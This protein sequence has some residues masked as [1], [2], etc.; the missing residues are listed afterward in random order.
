MTS[1]YIR[2]VGSSSRIVKDV[3]I[4]APP[5]SRKDATTTIMIPFQWS[6]LVLIIAVAVAVVVVVVG[7]SHFVVEGCITTTDGCTY[8]YSSPAGALEY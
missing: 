3:M 2:V 5:P 8:Y 1:K 4:K 6:I 7:Q